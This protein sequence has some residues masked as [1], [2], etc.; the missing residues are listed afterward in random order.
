[1]KKLTAV[2]IATVV[3][4][5]LFCLPAQAASDP[6]LDPVDS[7]VTKHFTMWG[8]GFN[9]GAKIRDR[10][11]AANFDADNAGGKPIVTTKENDD[12]AALWSAA[13]SNATLGCGFVA[14][15]LDGKKD[16]T[17]AEDTPGSIY[18][19]ALQFEIDGGLGDTV[20]GSFC[21]VMGPDSSKWGKKLN[22][23]DI[24]LG[25][26]QEVTLDDYKL[27]YHADNLVE[28]G[29]WETSTDGS[30]C[31]FEANFNEPMQ[32]GYAVLAL[33]Y[34]NLA[35]TY[36]GKLLASDPGKED[37]PI[38]SY[39][40]S[41]FAVFDKTL[42]GKPAQVGAGSTSAPETQAPETQAPETKAPETQAPQ[43][44]APETQ[45]PETQ[46]PQTREQGDGSAKKG[47]GGSAALAAVICCSAAGAALFR[48]KRR[49]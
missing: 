35:T 10:N 41:E 8:F 4:L 11:Y 17:G 5:S 34:D 45:A 3:V 43:T 9:G 19:A 31:F 39:L 36:E 13:S 30:F 42:D 48:R 46:A 44:Q 16:I 21:F 33:T 7:A 29:L 26:T 22:G 18:C 6:K 27:A 2:I 25:T 47:C 37:T 38:Y 28:F 23:F 14:T 24:W 15:G 40:M 12:Q 1:M 32:A 49:S 20:C